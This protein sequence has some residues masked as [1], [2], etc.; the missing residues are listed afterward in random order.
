MLRA[1]VL[2]AAREAVQGGDAENLSAFVE[3]ALDEKLRRTRR[4]TLYA[5]YD[6]ATRDPRFVEQM[7]SVTQELA[8]AD[9]DGLEPGSR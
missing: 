7:Q 9:A 1:D 3:D 6:A 2:T 4:A 8:A 5:A